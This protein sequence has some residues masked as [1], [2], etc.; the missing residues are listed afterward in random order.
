M[1]AANQRSKNF[2]SSLKPPVLQ[3]L[4]AHKPPDLLE[5]DE[6]QSRGGSEPAPD[7]DESPPEGG[8]ALLGDD[9]GEAVEGVGVELGVCGLVHEAGSDHVEGGDGASHEEAGAAGRHGLGEDGGLGEA[10][11]LDDET[12]D[13]VVA[14]GERSA[15]GGSDLAS[16]HIM[17]GD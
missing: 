2:V 4:H 8:G 11:L 13:L 3:G 7:G 5:D 14:A 16:K 15:S 1:F 12:L 10:G 9:L 6:L 17:M